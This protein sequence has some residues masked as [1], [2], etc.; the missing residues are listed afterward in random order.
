MG[1]VTPELLEMLFAPERPVITLSTRDISSP[2][3]KSN[4]ESNGSYGN[5]NNQDSYMYNEED[6]DDDDDDDDDVL[7]AREVS[8]SNAQ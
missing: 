1:Y 2:S 5:S 3:S 8:A 4:T 6:D 7:D